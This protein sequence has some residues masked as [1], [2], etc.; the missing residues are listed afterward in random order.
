VPDKH[1]RGLLDTSAMIVLDR[2]SAEDL[3]DEKAVSSITMAELAAGPHATK[4][5][6]ERARRMELL[7][8]AESTFDQLPFDELAARA[9]G[10]VYVAVADAGRKARGK[11]AV[12][13]LI[14]A[15]A[16][17]N[18][19]PLYTGNPADFNGLAGLLEV[20]AVPTV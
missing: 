8:R 5:P 4:D 12:D 16:L 2:L 7:Q 17:S 18:Q 14:A 13:L 6:R 15:I 1:A 3:P 9:Y 10:R 11:R 20:V 19:L